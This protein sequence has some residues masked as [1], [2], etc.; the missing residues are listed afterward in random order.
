VFTSARIRLTAWYVAALA[1]FLL[2]LGTAVYQLEEHQVRS[3]VDNGL[4]SISHRA[5]SQ[6]AETNLDIAMATI[7]PANTAP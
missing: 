2:A 5:R 3:N 1:L 7:T 6:V 4:R